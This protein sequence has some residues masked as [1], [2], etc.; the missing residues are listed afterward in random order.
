MAEI[1]DESFL[2]FDQQ[3]NDPEEIEFERSLKKKFGPTGS[4]DF[5]KKLGKWIIEGNQLNEDLSY[6]LGNALLDI[7]ENKSIREAFNMPGRGRPKDQ[8]K[9][10]RDYRIALRIAKMMKSGE[11]FEESAYQVSKDF[12][13]SDHTAEKAYKKHS[14]LMNKID[15]HEEREKRLDNALR[16]L[17][18]DQDDRWF[19]LPDY[20]ENLEN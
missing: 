17:H 8:E 20:S 19:Y 14:R 4:K 18:K 9:A 1:N 10:F 7:S 5:L 15:N 2:S 3:P 16:N 13:I 11:S 12:N 6:Y